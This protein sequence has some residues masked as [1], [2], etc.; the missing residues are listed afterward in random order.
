MGFPRRPVFE[1][2]VGAY[3]TDAGPG[4]LDVEH[5]AIEIHMQIPTGALKM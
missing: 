2:G 1:E 3:G 5:A 4:W